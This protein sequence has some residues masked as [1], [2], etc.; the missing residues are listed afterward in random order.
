MTTSVAI[1]STEKSIAPTPAESCIFS[2][3]K[4]QRTILKILTSISPSLRYYEQITSTSPQ[5]LA[6]NWIIHFDSSNL[7][8]TN[9]YDA[10]VAIQRYIIALIYYSLN[11]SGWVNCKALNDTSTTEYNQDICQD[12]TYQRILS[13]T[14]ECNWY[15]MKCNAQG[16]LTGIKLGQF[17]T[18]IQIN[19]FNQSLLYMVNSI[20]FVFVFPSGR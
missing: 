8:P 14:H 19:L 12:E 17:V 10:N 16:F 11:G 6:A 5:Y 4:R 13:G 1:S 18:P 20:V 7:C 3:E 9:K 2:K 15:G